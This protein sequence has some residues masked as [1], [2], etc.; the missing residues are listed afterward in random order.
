MPLISTGLAL[1]M[2]CAR[3]FKYDLLYEGIAGDVIKLTYR[4]Y[5]NNFARPAFSTGPILYA[6]TARA[7]RNHIPRC[8]HYRH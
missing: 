3:Y 1:F 4:E 5:T 2:A 6:P 7:D 8:A